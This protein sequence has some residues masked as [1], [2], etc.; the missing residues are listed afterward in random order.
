[1]RSLGTNVV[2][3]SPNDILTMSVP[4]LILAQYF[5]D[6][7]A[8]WVIL[9]SCYH[10]VMFCPSRG[11]CAIQNQQ[12]CLTVSLPKAWHN[13]CR[14][15][16]HI[17]HVWCRIWCLLFIP[18]WNHKS[19]VSLCLPKTKADQKLFASPHNC[20][21]RRRFITRSHGSIHLISG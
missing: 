6:I 10:P 4:L 12:V 11:T 3:M 21:T 1:M 16:P 17:S 18:C 5:S 14:S 7:F 19:Q 13:I 2:A 20:F 8:Q 15:L 9:S